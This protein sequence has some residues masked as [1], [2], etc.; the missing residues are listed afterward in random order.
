MKNKEEVTKILRRMFKGH[1]IEEKD[2]ET[3]LELRVF[4]PVVRGY[5]KSKIRMYDPIWLLEVVLR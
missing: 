2:L 1:F 5:L 3:M 4:W